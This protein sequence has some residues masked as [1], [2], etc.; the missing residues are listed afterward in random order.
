MKLSQVLVLVSLAFIVIG[1]ALAQHLETLING[2][3]L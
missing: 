1:L 2:I 3:L